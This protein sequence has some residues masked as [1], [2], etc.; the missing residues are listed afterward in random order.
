MVLEL[1]FT[2][3]DKLNKYLINI[4]DLFIF[5]FLEG[6]IIVIFLYLLLK[7]KAVTNPENPEPII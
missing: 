1:K 4:N 5:L 7:A 2:S 6:E 3:P